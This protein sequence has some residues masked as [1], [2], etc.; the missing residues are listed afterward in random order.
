MEAQC[1]SIPGVY[2]AVYTPVSKSLLLYYDECFQPQQLIAMLKKR[3]RQSN[4]QKEEPSIK[5]R[6]YLIGLCAFMYGVQWLVA[7]KAA[8]LVYMTVLNRIIGAAVLCL[9]L[10][11]IQNG[12]KGLVKERKFNPDFLTMCSLFACLYLK[13]PA[14][15]LIIYMMSTASEVLTDMTTVK[16]KAHLQSLL[17]LEAPHAWKVFDDNTVKKVGVELVC[18]EDVI[19]VYDGERIPVDGFIVNGHAFIDESAITGEYMPKEKTVQDEVYA[20]SICQSGEMT[21]CVTKTGRETALGRM[22][23]LIEEAYSSQAPTQEYANQMAE[24]M[25]GV[26]FGLTFLTYIVTRNLDRSL[27]ML[28]IDFVCGIKLSTAAAFSAAIGKAAQKGI[29]IKNGSYVEKLAHME[30]IVFDKTGTLTEGKPYVERTDCFH[31]FTEQEVL[32]A[33]AA[34]EQNSSHPLA[35]AILEEANKRRLPLSA[36]LVHEK[37][38]VVTGKGLFGMVGEKAVHIGSLR[39][40]EEEGIITE[41]HM[42]LSTKYSVYIAIDGCLAG[43]FFIQDRIR[44]GMEHTIKQL[45]A[46]GVRK[47]VMLTGDEQNNAEKVAKKLQ[48]DEYWAHMLPEEKVRYVEQKKKRAVIAMVGDGLNDAPAL[49]KADIGITLGG[50]RTD[51]AV[52]ASDIVI[53]KDDPHVLADLVDLSKGTLKT[54]KQNV[55]ATLFVNGGAILLGALGV[56]SPV[57]GAA[58]HNLATIGVVLNSMKI[59][60]KGEKNSDTFVYGSSRYSGENPA[61]SADAAEPLLI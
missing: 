7:K 45:R 26:S 28:V 15:A 2:S 61:A 21:V 50:K 47:V 42:D 29:L 10:S 34:L 16:T 58:V 20:G 18:V 41:H 52:E 40:L 13:Q 30:T 5:K 57:A 25:V 48:L 8:P 56:I 55:A 43:A 39:F 12:V 36:R 49:T 46:I 4:K 35:H 22:I 33:A 3:K 51:L 38:H 37:V 27:G 59:L 19:K 32:Q 23:E 31:D 53:S 24:K 44:P 17:H 6:T 9:S 1:R 54:V 14:S 60:A 11:T